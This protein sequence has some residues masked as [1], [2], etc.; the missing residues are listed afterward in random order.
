LFYKSFGQIHDDGRLR[1]D[2]LQTVRRFVDGI[3]RAA[4]NASAGNLVT[5]GQ[6]SSGSFYVP[7]FVNVYANDYSD[8]THNAWL[9]GNFQ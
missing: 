4:L 7:V 9:P 1:G 5:A 2:L 6:S 3:M 8:S